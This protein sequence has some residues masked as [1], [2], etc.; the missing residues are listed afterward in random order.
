MPFIRVNP[1]VVATTNSD[2]APRR[3]SR[4]AAGPA[5]SAAASTPNDYDVGYGKPP[6]RTQFQPGQSGN[7]RGRPKRSKGL[8]TIIREQLLLPIPIQTPGGT[9]RVTKM[10][11]LVLKGVERAAKGEFRALKMIVDL[12]SK[13]VP[14]LQSVEA[15]AATTEDLSVTDELTLALL[16]AQIA[17]EKDTNGEDEQ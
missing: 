11:A 12:Y 3:R 6:K 9:K 7:P 4:P 17:L 5:A 2:P 8:N 1:P 10:E 15:G 16:R 13:A 14:D